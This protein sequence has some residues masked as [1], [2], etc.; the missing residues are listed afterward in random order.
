MKNFKNNLI[1]KK[2]KKK[3]INYLILNIFNF[4]KYCNNM[5]K[6]IYF[7]QLKIKIFSKL[8]NNKKKICNPN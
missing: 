4:N 1:F 5:K 8:N 6:K 7:I 3:L 2:K